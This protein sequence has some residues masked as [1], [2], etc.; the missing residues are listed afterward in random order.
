MNMERKEPT[1]NMNLKKVAELRELA[2]QASIAAMTA[3]PGYQD[4]VLN[5][6]KKLTDI[7]DSIERKEKFAAVKPAVL[8]LPCNATVEEVRKARSRQAIRRGDDIYLPS[9]SSMALVLPNT[10]LRTALFSTGSRVQSNSESILKGDQS[11]LVANK[12]IATFP[13]LTLTLSGYEL[14]QFDRHVYA[15]CLDYYREMALSPRYSSHY[16]KTTFYEFSRRMGL[17]YGLNPHKAIRASLL[18]LSLAKLR[19]R[20]KKLDLEI[21]SLLNTRFEDGSASGAF[22]GSDTILLQITEFVAELFGPGAWTAVDKEAA[23]YDGV[24]GWL[25]SFYSGHSDTA[26]LSVK[27]LYSISGYQSKSMS[28][29]KASLI[30]ALDKLKDVRTPDC[31]RVSGYYFTDDGAKIMVVRAAWDKSAL[32]A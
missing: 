12:E 9:Y 28:N 3:A 20:Q 26:W 6:A 29:F 30:R 16:V 19:V 21:P 1:A 15:I 2:S 23:R 31:C 18:R 24:M 22:K 5:A 17:S 10:L 7:A 8:L 13:N 32:P 14:C 11:T 25:A 27:S 4:T